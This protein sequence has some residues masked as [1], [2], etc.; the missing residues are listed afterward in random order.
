MPDLVGLMAVMR[1]VGND[2]RE[3]CH[4]IEGSVCTQS[5]WDSKDKIPEGIGEPVLVDEENSLWGVKPSIYYC[6]L[7]TERIEGRLDCILV[8]GM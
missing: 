6:A 1:A 8:E 7:C 2:E 5:A 4:Y 3:V